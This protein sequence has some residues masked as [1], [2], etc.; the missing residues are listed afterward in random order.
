MKKKVF[1]ITTTTFV[2]LLACG[3][4][5]AAAQAEPSAKATASVGN[6]NMLTASEDP[7]GAAPQWLEIA[8]NGLHTSAQKD[9]FCTV[10]LEV[11]LYTN[12][13]VASGGDD[14]G[15][16]NNG[17]GGPKSA[18]S[19]AAVKVRVWVD[20][21]LALPGEV[22]YGSRIQTLEANFQ[23]FI[24]DC[25][26]LD[27]NGN[28][29]VNQECIEPETLRL[30]LNTM[31]AASFSFVIPDPGVGNHTI[32]CEALLTNSTAASAG[33]SAASSAMIGKGSMTVEEVR[34]VQGEDFEM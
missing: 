31:H 29:V 28:P 34:M 30:I 16:G 27:E 18:T 24:E 23:G 26:E 33:S 5:V 15:N 7:N 12:T 1:G 3:M 6:I 13:F 22:V 20:D 19:E 17:N 14:G 11:G 10:S 8:S 4:L 21:Q 9:I 25:L 2:T 32:K